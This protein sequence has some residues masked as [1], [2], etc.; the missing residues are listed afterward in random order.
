L[1]RG[2]DILY[3]LQ[4]K[5][6]EL[7]E[8][9]TL[10]QEIPVTIR[11]LE[12][13]RDAKADMMAQARQKLNVNVEERRQLEKDILLIREKIAKYKEQMKKVSTNKEYQGFISEIKFEESNI[14]GVEEKIIEKMV[15]SDA[16]MESIRQTEG[17]FRKIADE[18]NRRI[19]DLQSHMDYNRKK[20]ADETGVRN[21]L[22]SRVDP[23]LLKVYESLFKKKIGKAVSF[24]SSDFC[25]VC[26][27]KIRPQMLSELVTSSDILICE[28]C[29]RI[30]FKQLQPENEE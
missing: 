21:E 12:E 15:E 22:K 26:H 28:N 3:A 6:D 16:I 7:K 20:L 1:K 13:E 27:I 25:G 10:I 24:V 17:E 9:E 29:G 23:A 5:D 4:L 30:L 11:G 18:Y 14:S 8:I 19:A 2:L